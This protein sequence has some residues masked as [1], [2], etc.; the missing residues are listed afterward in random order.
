MGGQENVCGFNKIIRGD[1]RGLANARFSKRQRHFLLRIGKLA[2]TYKQFRKFNA[3]VNAVGVWSI[4]RAG[5]AF[6]R[7][8]SIA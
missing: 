7:S 2:L 4:Q 5:K 1:R 6:Q 3:H 8:R